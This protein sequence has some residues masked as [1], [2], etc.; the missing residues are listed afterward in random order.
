MP[1][2]DISDDAASISRRQK[3]AAGIVKPKS[4]DVGE[5]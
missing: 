5:Y 4:I 1:E 2:D 3:E